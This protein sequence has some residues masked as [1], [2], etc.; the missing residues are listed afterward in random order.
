MFVDKFKVCNLKLVVAVIV[1]FILL[2]SIQLHGEQS[3]G[4]DWKEQAR[5]QKLSQITIDK[6][7]KNKIVI[8]DETHKQIFSVYI[9]GGGPLFI[10]TDSLINAYHV[11]YEESVLQ[12]EKVNADKLEKILRFIL[13][14]LLREGEKSK[15]KSKL[16]K[17]AEERAFIIVGTAL[18]L[19]D[20]N[21]RF[22]NA[23]IEEIIS[24]EV[25]KIK[26]ATA[27]DKP[28][29]LG[30]ITS[31][32]VALDYSRYK[33]R[34]FYTSSEK[35]SNYFRSVSWLQSIP[36]RVSKNEELLS[37]LMLGSCLTPTQ[38]KEDKAKQQ[39]YINFFHTF[40][41]LIGLGDD[42]DVITAAEHIEGILISDINEN[43][44]VKI[45][46]KLE[47]ELKK[48]GGPQINDQVRFPPLDPNV[49]AEPQFRFI[50]A[51]RTPDAVLFQR[52]TDLR[53]FSR[54][55]PNGLEICT[56]LGSDFAR[57]KL[58]YSDKKKLLKVID[59]AKSMF[60]GNTLYLD[61]LGCL[62]CLLDEPPSGSPAFMKNNVWKA[63]SCNTV[64]AGWSQLRHTWL[65]QAK[66]TVMYLCATITSA[67]FVEPNPDFYDHMAKLAEK[68]KEVLENAGVFDLAL[69]SRDVMYYVQLCEKAGSE[70][71]LYSEA[72]NMPEQELQRLTLGSELM[73]GLHSIDFEKEIKTDFKYIKPNFKENVAK[74]RTIAKDLQKDKL[75]NDE[76]L[77]NI[78]QGYSLKFLWDELVNVSR[79]L[80]SISKKQLKGQD[81]TEYE[82][83]IESYGERIACI[84]LYYGNSYVEPKDDSP[85]IADVCYNPTQS[86]GYLHVGIGRPRTLYVLYPWQRRQ[87]L[88]IGAVM[89]YYEFAHQTRLND[90]E[91]KEFLGSNQRPNVPD[92]LNEVISDNSVSKSS[93]SKDE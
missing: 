38:F 41:L 78:I 92:W 62:A 57:N 4:L 24:K 32:L 30:D 64:L 40:K 6:L 11:L 48:T 55:F 85:K 54:P 7:G 21:F 80:E 26:Q 10:T 93:F 13:T 31:D 15:S 46:L 36:F 25:E 61:Y 12:L 90:S 84:M 35:L 51:Y 39:E 19:L 86:K 70:D 59:D 77:Q 34:G 79:T 17:T 29:W 73:E 37:I 9:G 74:L 67:G 75:P 88:C 33:P 16:V 53:Q 8:T 89:P 69:M 66:Q 81:L 27:N 83:F 14:N 58:S 5:E 28:S 1:I 63:K 42:W 71:A 68:S 49:I 3:D 22:D 65:L 76:Q 91:W 43:D 45:R 72:R 18:K 56:V 82:S 52:T 23:K 20:D 87:I 60:S 2:L 44:L 50:S 47:N